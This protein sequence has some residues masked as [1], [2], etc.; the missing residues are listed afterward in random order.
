LQEPRSFLLAVIEFERV[1]RTSPF[2]EIDNAEDLTG[3][4]Q[5]N[6]Q[7]YCWLFA[8]D[9]VGSLPNPSKIFKGPTCRH[10]TTS[11]TSS[12]F[13]TEILEDPRAPETFFFHQEK[14]FQDHCA[15]WR[16]ARSTCRDKS[17][18]TTPTTHVG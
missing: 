13:V 14:R 17:V 12:L 16:R 7:R 3:P 18:S 8:L 9:G 2:A 6:L 10:I 1:S 5:S 4:R 15:S 11:R